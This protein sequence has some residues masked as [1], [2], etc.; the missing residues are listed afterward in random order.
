M[1]LRGEPNGN[2]GDDVSSHNTNVNRQKEP[3][4]TSKEKK[5]IVMPA[6]FVVKQLFLNIQL[7]SISTLSIEIKCAFLN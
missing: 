2:Q 7:K 3:K 1:F 4:D 6:S 5:A